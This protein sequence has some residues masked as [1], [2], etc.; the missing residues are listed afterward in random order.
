MNVDYQE[1]GTLRSIR[2]EVF[3]EELSLFCFEA[4]VYI[5]FSI[6]QDWKQRGF[7][8]DFFMIEVGCPEMLISHELLHCIGFCNV[9]CTFEVMY[10]NNFLDYKR[11]LTI[12]AS[13]ERKHFYC[14]FCE[15]TESRRYCFDCHKWGVCF[16]GN[17]QAPL[18]DGYRGEY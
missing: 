16:Y 6:F 11:R 8:R 9:C 10:F 2:K 13:C 5:H 3:L 18:Y 7:I 17:G 14:Q 4:P 1:I 15:S 12:C